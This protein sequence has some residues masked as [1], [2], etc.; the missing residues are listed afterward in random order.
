[1][2]STVSCSNY[3]KTMHIST[4]GYS[5]D[6]KKKVFDLYSSIGETG[7]HGEGDQTQRLL[8]PLCCCIVRSWLQ[9]WRVERTESTRGWENRN[10][11][12]DGFVVTEIHF[13][14]PSLQLVVQPGLSSKFQVSLSYTRRLSQK[15]RCWQCSSVLRALAQHVEGLRFDPQH[16][17]H[18]RKESERSS[19]ECLHSSITDQ[20]V[21]WSGQNRAFEGLTTRM[22]VPSLTRCVTATKHAA[23]YVHSYMSVQSKVSTRSQQAGKVFKIHQKQ[24]RLEA[25]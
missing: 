6:L 3:M 19:A 2:R 12:G 18:Y 14:I 23:V 22:V 11:R 25:T 8:V 7:G 13:C 4:M 15:K 24:M 10:K 5:A 16:N 17:Y 20:Q 1:M 21:L 9:K